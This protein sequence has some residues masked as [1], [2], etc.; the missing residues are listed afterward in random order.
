VDRQHNRLALAAV[1]SIALS[2]CGSTGNEA[3]PS[4][5]TVT[6]TAEAPTTPP[7]DSSSPPSAAPPSSGSPSTSPSSVPT[8]K[9]GQPL[10]LRE[11]HSSYPEWEER[12]YEVADSSDVRAMGTSVSGC[13]LVSY[14]PQLEFRLANRFDSLSMK[15]AQAN[16]SES[17]DQT[18]VVVIE[19]NDEQIDVRQVPF[20]EVVSI[21]DVNIDG[22][23][24]LRVRLYLDDEDE[25]CGSSG[26]SEVTAVIEQLVVT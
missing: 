11:A 14:S 1:L 16:S 12:L 3:S 2:G 19:G 24:A 5:S 25:D 21:A 7:D 4:V 10:S 18:L 9:I 17:S 6:V 26:T 8:E 20:N 15:V 22:V 23:N 13:G